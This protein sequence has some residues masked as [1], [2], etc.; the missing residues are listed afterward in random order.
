[1][2]PIPE[3]VGKHYALVIIVIRVSPCCMLWLDS[4]E[5]VHEDIQQTMA[6]WFEMLAHHVL[7]ITSSPL[8]RTCLVSGWR[9]SN[10]VIPPTTACYM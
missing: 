7:K 4:F 5:G 2:F 3:P 1:M 8:S 10:S 9:L 6:R